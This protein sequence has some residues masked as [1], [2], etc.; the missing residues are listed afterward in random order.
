[1]LLPKSMEKPFQEFLQKVLRAAPSCENST[2]FGVMKGL[3]VYKGMDNRFYCRQLAFEK[4]ARIFDNIPGVFVKEILWE[5]VFSLHNIERIISED[6][7]FVEF[8]DTSTN[9]FS[10]WSVATSLGMSP[11]KIKELHDF[12]IIKK[13]TQYQNSDDLE[14][15]LLEHGFQEID[16]DLFDF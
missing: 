16:F 13:I 6:L 4:E 11:R 5:Q 10:H 3:T 14:R 2:I 8:K 9:E 12:N 1:M 7:T 15:S